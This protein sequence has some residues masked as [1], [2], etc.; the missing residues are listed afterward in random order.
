MWGDKNKNAKNQPQQGQQQQGQ[1]QQQNQQAQGQQGQQDQK[2]QSQQQTQQSQQQSQVQ[3]PEGHVIIPKDQLEAITKRLD[4]LEQRGP[5]F[6]ESQHVQQ[7][8]LQT[9]QID[10][11]LEEI[12]KQ[13]IEIDKEIDKRV[14]EG[15]PYSDL[16]RKR[17]LLVDR[18]VEL[19][20]KAQQSSPT[21]WSRRRCLI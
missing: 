5:Q 18:K 10:T 20:F 2:G 13:I 19:R 1:L 14:E 17:D 9:P 3:V 7:P 6:A 16:S 15:K 4:Y 21:R 12:D 8:Q 11:Q